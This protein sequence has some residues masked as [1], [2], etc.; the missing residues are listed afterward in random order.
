MTDSNHHLNEYTIKDKKLNAAND[1]D[2]IVNNKLSFNGLIYE[3]KK[4]IFNFRY[5]KKKC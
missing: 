4:R 1:L 3:K 5:Y 2:V